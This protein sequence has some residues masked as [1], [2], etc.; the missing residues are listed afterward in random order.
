MEETGP[1]PF[2]EPPTTELTNNTQLSCT[3]S[4]ISGF[5]APEVQGRQKSPMP[6]VFGILVVILSVVG[7]LLNLLAL[8]T[9][10]AEIDMAREMGENSTLFVTWSWIQPILSI[11]A[12]II[13][14]Y[15]GLQLYNYKKN[16]IFIGLGAVAFNAIFGLIGA[17]VQSQVQENISGSA[18]WGAFT[19][20]AEGLITILCNGCCA[21]LLVIPLMITPQ[22]L[23]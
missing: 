20:G 4:P 14:G 13:F 9:T 22:D 10:Q 1:S 16:S 2:D 15:A 18:E 7:V 8:L 21:I 19:G 17:Y 11:V 3:P 12:M 23:E 5:V 6:Q